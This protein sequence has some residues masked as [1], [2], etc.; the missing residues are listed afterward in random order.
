[1]IHRENQCEMS[2]QN[3]LF[4]IIGLYLFQIHL[5]RPTSKKYGVLFSH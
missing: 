4:L 3:D 1:M 5:A 2:D